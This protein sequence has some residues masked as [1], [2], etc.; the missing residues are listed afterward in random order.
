MKEIDNKEINLKYIV[1]NEKDKNK[2]FINFD[3]I[4]DEARGLSAN[5]GYAYLWSSVFSVDKMYLLMTPQKE[6]NAETISPLIPIAKGRKYYL[7]FTDFKR[8]LDFVSESNLIKEDEKIICLEMN[9]KSDLDWLTKVSEHLGVNNII[10]NQGH[11]S[12]V[13]KL[14][15]LVG[16]KKSISI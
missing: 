7:I 4:V 2:E 12:W 3:D 6:V 10:F 11:Y 5:E 15:N 14:D 16:I 1:V 8:I 9:L 13:S